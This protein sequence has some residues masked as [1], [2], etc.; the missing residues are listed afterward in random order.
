MI[1]K[2]EIK[3]LD[4]EMGKCKADPDCMKTQKQFIDPCLR[5]LKKKDIK[6]FH[7]LIR[8]HRWRIVF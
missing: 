5:E 7:F 4:I 8:K 3:E 2:K 1:I 6:K